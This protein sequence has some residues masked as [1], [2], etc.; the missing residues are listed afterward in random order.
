MAAPVNTVVP[1][2]TGTVAVGTAL[3]LSDGTWTGTP[4]SYAY[5]WLADGV[6]ITGATTASYTVTRSLIGAT[7][8]GRVTATNGDGSTAATSAGQAVPATLVVEDGTAKADADSYISAAA[9]DTYHDKRGNTAWAALTEA[10]KE[11]HLRAAT[12]YL[13]QIYRKRWGGYRYTATQSL[14]WPR[15]FVYL[16]P[17]VHGAVGTYPYLV[18][19]DVVPTEVAN[20]CA[21]LAL[22]AIDGALFA[23]L[24]QG[25]VREKIGP[26]ETEYDRN[27]PQAAR[28]VAVEAMLAPYLT[29]GGDSVRVVRS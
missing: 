24:A 12:D 11:T 5:A 13:L 14:D 15:S 8:T 23:D 16:E 2:I 6:A 28:Y 29:R 27:S 10:A 1:A 18:A 17:F 7:L 22:R 9:A 26:L 20:A 21:E 25:V 19:N 4:T 3:S